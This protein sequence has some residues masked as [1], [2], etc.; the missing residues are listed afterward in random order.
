M[1]QRLLTT[2]EI[3]DILSIVTFSPSIPYKTRQSMQDSIVFKLKK[4]LCKIKV[5]PEI[6]PQLKINIER[7]YHRSKC[8]Y[9]EAVGILMGQ[10]IGENQTQ[11][12]LNSFHA[13]GITI[14]LVSTGIPRFNELINA[15]AS[16][17]FNSLSIYL[18]NQHLKTPKEVRDYIGNTLKEVRLNDLLSSTP[19]IIQE[20]PEWVD[21]APS[22]DNPDDDNND[23]EI[24]ILCDI[25]KSIIF[26]YRLDLKSIKEILENKYEDVTVLYSPLCFLQ[27]VLIC[28]IPKLCHPEEYI[29]E[30]LIP[31]LNKC[32]LF[33]IEGIADFVFTRS[34]NEWVVQTSGTNF[35]HVIN[36][37]KFDYTTMS[38]NNLWE[39][40]NTLGV[41]A[42]REFLFTELKKVLNDGGWVN[43]RHIHVLVDIMTHRGVITSVSRYGSRGNN[44]SPLSRVSFEETLDN[45]L[46][47]SYTAEFEDLKSISSN[48]MTGK[49]PRIGTGF[50][51]IV[52][53]FS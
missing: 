37:D 14:N 31:Q 32:L 53:D 30:Y 42:T 47:A 22:T 34:E 29:F 2:T 25:D 39:V 46:R 12:T 18:S 5:D 33:G 19:R 10:S 9:G 40:Y 36:L 51:D 26:K 1:T 13:A 15:T 23:D 3:D 4:Q 6:I 17:K 38:T 52:Q 35:R 24:M 21:T 8:A 48:V 16:Q 49:M 28:K 11:S 50:C 27:I 20:L 41:E 7:E 45:F 43:D 44:L